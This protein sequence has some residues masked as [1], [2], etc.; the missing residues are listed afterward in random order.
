MDSKIPYG[1]KW[2]RD[3]VPDVTWDASTQ[4][5]ILPSGQ[6]LPKSMYTIVDSKAYV[7]PEDILNYTNKPATPTTQAVQPQTATS[8]PS[9]YTWIRDLVPNVS[10]DATNKSIT[11][12]TGDVLPYNMYTIVDGK[13]YVNPYALA[14]YYAPKPLDDQALQGYIERARGIYQ[15]TIDNQ[16]ERINNLI[17][18]LQNKLEASIQGINS[19]AEIARRNLQRQQTADSNQLRNRSIARGTYTSG[20]ADY[21]QGKLA[22]EY[23]GRYSDLESAVASAIASANADISGQMSDLS[24]QASTIEDQFLDRIMNLVNLL[25]Q[26]DAAAQADQ[27]NRIIQAA[28]ASRSQS[29]MDLEAAIARTEMFGRVVTE[30][31]AKALGVPIGTP[32]YQALINQKAMQTKS[33]GGGSGG[34]T[35]QPITEGMDIY[36]MTPDQ[37]RAFNAALDVWERTGIAPVGILQNFGVEAGTGYTPEIR[38][39]LQA[40]EAQA[41]ALKLIQDRKIRGSMVSKE[42][43]AD[44]L[45]R[46]NY[47][48]AAALNLLKSER[49]SLIAAGYDVKEI[50]RIIN[51]FDAKGKVT[52]QPIQTIDSKGNSVP[53]NQSSTVNL[54]KGR[55]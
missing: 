53:L 44:C 36:N 25:V 21:E 3:L 15:P 34:G 27:Y 24:Y 28:E 52:P 8:V 32:S 49:D 47:N 48:R 45:A 50:E 9:G 51:D 29:A 43:A 55:R 16:Y 12:P 17:A 23:A 13:S 22:G 40:M 38:A 46:T 33:Y 54:P 19:Q 37:Q 30:A 6:V 11:L 2:I 20:V 10:W 1:T 14:N 41:E 42:I 5:I 7:R 18:T 26:Q 4:S 35:S 31:D 39:E